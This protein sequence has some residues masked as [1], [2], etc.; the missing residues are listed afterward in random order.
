MTLLV[1]WKMVKLQVKV[2]NVMRNQI[3][4]EEVYNGWIIN[5]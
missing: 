4:G 1:E 3:S 2:D 5:M